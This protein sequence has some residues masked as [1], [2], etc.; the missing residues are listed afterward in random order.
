MTMSYDRSPLGAITNVKMNGA[1]AD[2]A[3]M[4]SLSNPTSNLQS[5]SFPDHDVKIGDTWTQ[6]VSYEMQWR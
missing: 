4:H 5:W 6:K 2:L 1:P 3:T